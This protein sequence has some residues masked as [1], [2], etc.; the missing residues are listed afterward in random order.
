MVPPLKGI[1]ANP[2]H[3][4]SRRNTHGEPAHEPRSAHGGPEPAGIVLRHHLVKMV[5]SLTASVTLAHMGLDLRPL[6][7]SQTTGQ[8]GGKG[9]ASVVT[10]HDEETDMARR[11]AGSSSARPAPSTAQRAGSSLTLTG[12]CVNA[13]SPASSPVNRAPPPV[14]TMPASRM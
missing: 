3:Q 10:A 5:E 7:Q 4:H 1:P 2:H 8:Q 12:R 14:R 13:R 11:R 9:L 6:G